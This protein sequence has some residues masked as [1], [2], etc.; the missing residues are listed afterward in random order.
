MVFATETQGRRE[1]V[2]NHNSVISLPILKFDENKDFENELHH[3]I[4]DLFDSLKIPRTAPIGVYVKA[5]FVLISFII[6][7]LLLV[8]VIENLWQGILLSAILGFTLVGIGVNVQHDGSHNAYSQYLWINRTMAM[9]ADFIGASSYFW[10]WKHNLFHHSFTN[11]SHFDTDIDFGLLVR[12]APST[13]L[14]WF[15]RWQHL[16]IWPF[17]GFLTIKWQLFDDFYSL[18]RGRQGNH[19]VP[20]P[21]GA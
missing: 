7:Y 4:N 12:M 8:F 5:L 11:I 2:K 21:R 1:M 16:Y 9:T 19:K 18:I 10:R 13:D 3:R 17:Y 14:R 15:H 20:R 6:T